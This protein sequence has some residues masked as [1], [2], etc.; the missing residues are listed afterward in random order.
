MD[1]AQQDKEGVVVAVVVDLYKASG[2][3]NFDHGKC[4]RTRV[5]HVVDEKDIHVVVAVEASYVMFDGDAC[6]KTWSVESVV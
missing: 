5:I 4:F 2:I 3:A 1:P 6:D